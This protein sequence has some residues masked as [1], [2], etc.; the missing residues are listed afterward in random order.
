[1]E[2][3]AQWRQC[4]QASERSVWE[5]EWRWSHS[6]PVPRHHHHCSP[7]EGVR[8]PVSVAARVYKRQMTGASC[9]EAYLEWEKFPYL[10]LLK[11]HRRRRHSNDDRGEGETRH[12]GLGGV[13][14][15]DCS[16]SVRAENKLS[17]IMDW[18]T[19]AG[20]ATGFITTRSITGAFPASLYAKSAHQDWHCR[21][22]TVPK[23]MPQYKDIGRQLVEDNP[24]KMIK[25]IMGGG[26]RI[27][28]AEEEEEEDS[29]YRRED[30]R[31]LVEEW[32]RGKVE[33]GR[34]PAYVTS[35][36]ELMRIDTYNTD[37]LL[38][39]FAP[40]DLPFSMERNR[41]LHGTPSLSRMTLKALT[42]LERE[43]NGYFLMVENGLINKAFQDNRPRDAL[44]EVIEL[45][46]AVLLAMSRVNQ[47]E[48]LVLMA[49]DLFHQ[50]TPDSDLSSDQDMFGTK[51]DDLTTT[52]D[53][54][55]G[56]A[57]SGA[58][59]VNVEAA[60]EGV[61]ADVDASVPSFHIG[62][63][64]AIFA[65]EC[66]T[67]GLV[68]NYTT[69]GNATL[70]GDEDKLPASLSFDDNARTD[71]IVYSIL[72]VIAA[73]G[74]LTVFITLWRNRHRK[75]RVNL[76]IMHLA[77]ADLMVTF[78][79]F[80]LEISWLA[81]TQWL[82]GNLACKIFLFFRAFGLYLSSLV[83]VCIS[84]DRYFAIVHPLKSII[85]HVDSHP[86][87]SQFKQCVTFGFFSSQVQETMYNLFCLAAMYFLP[88]LIIIIVYFRILWEIYQNSKN[89]AEPKRRENR[90]SIIKA[91]RERRRGSTT[92]RRETGGSRT[93][94]KMRLR[95]SD[96]SNIERARSR[97]LKMTVIIVLAFVWCWTP[98]VVI[99]LWTVL[100]TK[101][102]HHQDFLHADIESSPKQK[103]IWMRVA[104]NRRGSQSYGTWKYVWQ[105]N[106]NKRSIML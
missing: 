17:S 48:T 91:T 11:G 14:K 103:R 10:G 19:Q 8:M 88:L 95:R 44:Q 68:A 36:V 67:D 24:G 13:T 52:G 4:Y 9:K 64:A 57:S 104:G 89:S 54:H 102:H 29:G 49:S 2:S 3:R 72:F 35:T 60:V 40:E 87:F 98:Y 61:G 41:G 22:P 86:E 58:G 55:K 76:M 42:L 97:T 84:L 37:Y 53:T 46:D 47:T 62:K 26:R 16:A 1:M 96:T 100:C 74:N 105:R 71:I 21:T 15:G 77:A 7:T 82:A 75:S 32:R 101:I 38:G 27:F 28:G 23:E 83:L 81:T 63:D 65:T 85:F 30:G 34:T 69:S 56:A 80:P 73:A 18:A 99:V 66:E 94:E 31:N 79:N 78:I 106:Y 50:V 92:S 5:C 12:P 59:V 25:V 70:A 90:S 43:E 93:G 51:R 6:L 33:E 20:M 39:L 45:E